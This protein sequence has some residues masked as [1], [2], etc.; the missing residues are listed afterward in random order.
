MK[1]II[2]TVFLIAIISGCATIPT[3]KISDNHYQN[4]QY[5]FALDMPG[6]EWKVSKTMPEW[7]REA[8]SEKPDL[9]LFNNAISGVLAIICNKSMIQIFPKDGDS[10]YKKEFR[11]SMRDSHRK[12][13]EAQIKKIEAA[14]K[15]NPAVTSFTYE[16]RNFYSSTEMAWLSKTETEDEMLK[17]GNV[18]KIYIYPLEND[19]VYVTI[20]IGY[21]RANQEEALRTWDKLIE[22]FKH[23][24][25]YSKV[26]E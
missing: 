10:I 19:T 11:A 20:I 7:F 16:A 5:G 6:G 22:S 8:I 14:N 4:Y 24:D 23:G 25:E 9:L 3:S 15:N 26:G 21:L 17:M 1:R 18:T 2:I 13:M 12:N